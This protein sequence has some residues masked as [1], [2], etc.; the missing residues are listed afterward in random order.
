MFQQKLRVEK[1]QH[2]TSLI[3]NSINIP[4]QQTGTNAHLI[5]EKWL[6]PIWVDVYLLGENEKQAHL[7]EAQMI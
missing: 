5:D 3:T 1:P 7:R 6:L 4:L 2:N